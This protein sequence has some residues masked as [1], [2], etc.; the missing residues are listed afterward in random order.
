MYGILFIILADLSI[1]SANLLKISNTELKFIASKFRKCKLPF[2]A[3]SIEDYFTYKNLDLIQRNMDISIYE[4]ITKRLEL[5]A[6][7][8]KLS[9][10]FDPKK[11][12]SISF[13][14]LTWAGF[15]SFIA[16]SIF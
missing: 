7:L 5:N 6:E 16:R 4:P 8:S 11:I 1:Q 9:K 3:A 14:N 13:L 15:L 12:K 10:C 2:W